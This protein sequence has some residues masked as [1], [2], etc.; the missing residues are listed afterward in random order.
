M[1]QSDFEHILDRV[2]YKLTVES[3]QQLFR[4]AKEF[5]DRVRESLHEILKFD[6]SFE[7]DF[8][9]NPQ[10]FPDIALDRFGVEVKFTLNDTWRSV[11]NSVLETNRIESVEKVYLVFGKM[12]GISEVR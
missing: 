5:E 7:I 11:A 10:A 1:N 12:G 6:N 9:P 8:N 3:R 4:T 2:C